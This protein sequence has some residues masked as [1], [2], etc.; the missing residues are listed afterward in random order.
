MSPAQNASPAPTGSISGDRETGA[1]TAL[2]TVGV[3]SAFVTGFQDDL[4]RSQAAQGIQHRVGLGASGENF[5]FCQA[6][7]QNVAFFGQLQKDG[8]R[9]V[10][11]PEPESAYSDRT[12]P[13]L[14]RLEND[15][16]T[17]RSARDSTHSVP[18]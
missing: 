4:G 8:A 14:R 3:P 18:V 10:R 1:K 6:G 7:N 11:G 2:L 17:R 15:P 13:W 16:P 9:L 5:G 12:P